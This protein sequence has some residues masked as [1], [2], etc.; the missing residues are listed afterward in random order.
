[1]WWYLTVILTSISM[2][3]SNEHFSMCV[4]TNCISSW[5]MS[6]S[7]AHWLGFGILF[8]EFYEFILAP[9]QMCYFSPIQG[10]FLHFTDCF[11]SCVG[12]FVYFC[13]C[14]WCN[15]HLVTKYM[16]VFGLCHVFLYLITSGFTSK[17]LIHFNFCKCSNSGLVFI[18]YK[19]L[20]SFSEPLTK[21]VLL[22]PVY[23]LISFIVD[24]LAN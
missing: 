23:T 18:T 9:C 6:S 17:S 10:I 12:T 13:L 24:Q 14:F 22:A 16:F 21:E 2:L 5:K 15:S 8:V 19:W 11:F 3:L 4:L 1:M 20:S 7:S